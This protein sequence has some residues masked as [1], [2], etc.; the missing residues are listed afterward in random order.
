[1]AR[2]LLVLLL[3]AALLVAGFSRAELE[4]LE[5]ERVPAELLYLPEGPLLRAASLGHEETLAD[6]LYIWAIQYYSSYEDAKTRFSYLE[7]VFGDAIAELDPRFVEIYIVGALL[8]S[9]E[10]RQPEMALRL[11]ER[12]LENN[13]QAWKLAYWAGWECFMAGRFEC[14]RDY[15]LRARDMPDAPPQLLRLATHALRRGGDL[16]NALE[17]YIALAENAPDEK[18]ANVAREWI[19]RLTT[20][21]GLARLEEGIANYRELHGR[22][23]PSLGALLREG[24]VRSMP[25]GVSGDA[26]RYDAEA[27]AVYPPSGD[28]FAGES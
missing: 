15:W 4:K 17:E 9:I 25:M 1:M 14:A 8:M 13:P 10:A 26:F 23:P 16:E 12:G 11:Y 5:D 22:C 21:I 20:R 7:K 28:T 2:V 18:T 19:R 27:C 6:L 24:L 3:A